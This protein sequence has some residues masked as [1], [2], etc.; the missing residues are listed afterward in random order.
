MYKII[1]DDCFNVMNK[2]I[3]NNKKVNL[4]ITS[5][6]YNTGRPNTSERAREHHEG[7][8]DIHTDTMSQEEYCNWCIDLFKKFDIILNANGCV[9]WNVSYGS[10]ASVNKVG[11]GLVW[12]VIADIIRN[13][14]FTVADKIVWKKKSALPNNVSPNKLT[15]ITEDIFV[16]CRKNEYKTF[17]M[18]KP[19][20]TIQEKTGQKFYHNV[21]NFI[22]A[23]NNDEPTKLN[24]ATFSS[25][26]VLFL[27]DLYGKK[28]EKYI[29][30]DP[31]GGT[32]TTAKACKLF[33][34]SNISSELSKEQCEYTI[35]RIDN[36]QV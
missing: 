19:V 20:K 23:K 3:A 31:F 18:N 9:L 15:R 7:R 27:L 29:V 5:P 30:Y 2:M 28:D 1:N 14:N 35:E 24:K 16:F 13:T 17:Y 34:C 6:P 4:I 25:E 33:G 8:Y 21:F 22:E 26:L 12:L 36:L 10:D 32:G 11:V